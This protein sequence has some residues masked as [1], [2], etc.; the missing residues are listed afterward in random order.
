MLRDENERGRE[1]G[2]TDGAM[3]TRTNNQK[4]R[5]PVSGLIACTATI[6]LKNRG[7]AAGE[8]EL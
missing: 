5:A 6:Q 1:K 7:G 3:I 4:G 2:E 8:E